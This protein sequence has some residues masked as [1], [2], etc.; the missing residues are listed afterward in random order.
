MPLPTPRV[1][2]PSSLHRLRRHRRTAAVAPRPVARLAWWSAGVLPAVGCLTSFSIGARKATMVIPGVGYQGGFSAGWAHAL[3]QPAYFTWLSNALVAGTSLTLAARDTAPTSD[4]FWALRTA[5]LGSVMV[6][7]I[8]YNAVLRGHE[9]DT[10]LYRVND[11]LQHVVN[12]VLAP[13]VWALF[14]PRGQITHRRAGLASVIPLLWAAMTMTRGR[15]IDWYPYPFLDVPRL[16]SRTV[17][18]VLV[19]IL[20]GFTGF[21]GMLGDLDRRLTPA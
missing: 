20:T 6:T 15:R 11:T 16:G 8:V 14:D 12:P 17:G 9:E 21:M 3:N 5:G 19:G 10:A 4:A 1:S 18:L 2:L 13:A 7:G